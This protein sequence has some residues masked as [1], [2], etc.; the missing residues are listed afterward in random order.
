MT[1]DQPDA[2]NQF[3]YQALVQPRVEGCKVWPSR[4]MPDDY[5]APVVSDKPVL[6]FSATQD[7]VTPR[8]WGDLVAQTLSNSMHV[9]A[10]GIG[11]GVFAYGCAP[12]LIA[13]FVDSG[14]LADVD[15]SCLNE[16]DTRPYF[17]SV[18]GSV[19]RDD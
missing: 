2:D 16:L 19:R 12:A 8:R 5:F 10:K 14:S 1:A 6:I 13:D 17:L 11:H 3:V 9:E 18:S 7:P 15:A 4:Q